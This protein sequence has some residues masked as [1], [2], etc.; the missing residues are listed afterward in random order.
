MSSIRLYDLAGAD[1]ERRFSPFC[2][3]TKL[4]LAHKGLPVESVPWRFTDKEVIAFSGQGRVP[5]IVDGENTV[6]D[7][8]TIATYLEDT[9]PEQRSLF[10]GD[11]G[12]AVTR[13]VNQWTDRVV[14]P[15]LA[16]LVLGDIFA[17]IHER[18]RAYFR[19]SRE[20]VFGMP[21]EQVSADRETK[22]HA[23]RQAIEPLRGLLQLQPY[24]AGDEPAYAD[25]IVFGAFQWAR[26]ISPFALL[27]E[28]D[29]VAAWRARMLEACGA[30]AGRAVAYPV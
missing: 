30:I 19:A 23:F 20:K 5:V 11:R 24:V 27:L 25:Y 14:H 8:W 10:G 15:A 2:W 26:C 28:D 3:R 21:L 9:Y 29:P 22:V 4:A 17:H 7:S 13:F 12:L 1:P 18:D 6:H 16:P